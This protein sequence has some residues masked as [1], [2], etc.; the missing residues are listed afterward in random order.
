MTIHIDIRWELEIIL[1]GLES[2]AVLKVHFFC[3]NQTI[4]AETVVIF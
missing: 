4:L 2:R 3:K 1:G